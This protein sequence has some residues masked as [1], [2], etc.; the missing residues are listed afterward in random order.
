MFREPQRRWNKRES[1]AGR[2][3]SFRQ[4]SRSAVR[5]KLELEVL[6][7]RMMLATVTWINPAGG[8]WDTPSNWSTLARPGP[9][10]DVVVNTLNAGADVTH[11][12]NVT[13]TIHSL[14]ASAPMTLS[15][16]KLDLSG[17]SSTAGA[18]SDSSPF[19]LA[20]GTLSLADVRAG[21]ALTASSSAVTWTARPWVA[22]FRC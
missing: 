4:R 10:D 9:G 16:G 3:K 6:E 5:R 19:F 21:T 17:G 13:D 11:T 7:D 1:R 12:Q 14:S 20:G 22:R 8:D 18:L 15:R 2:S